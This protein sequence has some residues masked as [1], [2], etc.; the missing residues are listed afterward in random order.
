[1]PLEEI[2]LLNLAIKYREWRADL[3]RLGEIGEDQIADALATHVL[4]GM[5][6]N[7]DYEKLKKA[8]VAVYHLG[9]LNGEHS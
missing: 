8:I 5:E 4:K 7:Q 1:M 9:R 3:L 2:N 6:G